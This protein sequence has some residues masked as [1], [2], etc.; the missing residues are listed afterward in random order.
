MN[1]KERVSSW[2]VSLDVIAT[3]STKWRASLLQINALI[4]G[5]KNFPESTPKR[6][7]LISQLVCLAG[8]DTEQEGIEVSM[9]QVGDSTRGKF[10]A[11][12]YHNNII[13]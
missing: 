13:A 5:I 1:T 12:V 9:G 4:H 10:S 3:K 8:T 11:T 2:N 6:W 7:S